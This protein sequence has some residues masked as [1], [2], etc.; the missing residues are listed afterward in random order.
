V[1]LIL[2]LLINK[3][4]NTDIITHVCIFF[5]L[6]NLNSDKP[7]SQSDMDTKKKI[8]QVICDEITDEVD[9]CK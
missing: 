9:K 3:H 8:I 2:N 6:N 5:F 1:A 4:K 7:V